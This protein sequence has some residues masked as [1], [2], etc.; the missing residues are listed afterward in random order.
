MRN[1]AL[2]NNQKNRIGATP[3]IDYGRLSSINRLGAKFLTKRVWSLVHQVE[4]P[5]QIKN[6]DAAY[7]EGTFV[8]SIALFAD[9]AFQVG[10]SA[11]QR[12]IWSNA[13][14]AV[15]RGDTKRDRRRQQG[16]DRYLT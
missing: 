11:S 10:R 8:I 4:F 15:D 16:N 12:K 7:V 5:I 14:D 13:S 3:T 9:P 2:H 1:P 6:E